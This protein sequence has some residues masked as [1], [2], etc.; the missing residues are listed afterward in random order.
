MT[1]TTGTR[2]RT[3]GGGGGGGG[4]GDEPDPSDLTEEQL[5]RSAA[6][7]FNDVD[8]DDYYAAAVGWMLAH[9]ITTG[10]TQASFCAHEQ[11]S[12]RHF[13]TF[14]W[15]AAGSPEPE[16]AGSEL[17]AD[18][19]AGGYADNAIGWALEQGVTTGCGANEDGERLFC[20]GR[21]ATRAHI[22]TFIYRYTGAD[23]EPDD[24]FADVDPDAYYSAARRVDA[25]PRHHHRMRRRRRPAPVLPR[26]RGHQSPRGRVPVPHRHHPRELGRQ[27]RHPKTRPRALATGASRAAPGRRRLGAP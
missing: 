16:Q 8:V 26:R 21:N 6:R 25:R 4:G 11:A 7:R 3:G 17:F 24:T 5:A 20:P 10:C 22:S 9:G 19:E 12:R 1:V 13:V 18:V 23:E 27:R 2:P 15:R 14:L